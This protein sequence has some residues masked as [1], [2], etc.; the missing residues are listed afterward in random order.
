MADDIAAQGKV[1]DGVRGEY[2]IRR[3]TV[4]RDAKKPFFS[5]DPCVQGCVRD[6][7]NLVNETEDRLA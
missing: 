1:A 5:M 7:L 4:F 2:K 6:T 3:G